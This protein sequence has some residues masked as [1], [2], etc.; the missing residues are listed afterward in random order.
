MEVF[1]PSADWQNLGWVPPRHVVNP[2]VPFAMSNAGRVRGKYQVTS[3]PGISRPADNFNASVVLD[4][5]G[6]GIEASYTCNRAIK[7]KMQSGANV[8]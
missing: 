2:S 3:V 1:S 6:D 4:V 5:D 7:A 8:Y